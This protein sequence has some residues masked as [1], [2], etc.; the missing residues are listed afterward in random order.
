MPNVGEVLKSEIS[1]L[2]KKV[3]KQQVGPL[4]SLAAGQRRQLAALNKQVQQLQRE[5]A[6]LRRSAAKSAPA[7]AEPEEGGTKNRFTAK[8][9]RS[10]RARLDLSAE[11]FGKLVD[12]GAQTVYNWESEKNSPRATQVAAIAGLRKIG[13][14]EA[15]ARLEELAG[16]AG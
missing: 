8:G 1:R 13:K 4:R 12:V 9:L 3:V 7:A 14:K 2:S 11:E 5:I 6:A 16:N 10:L 15:R